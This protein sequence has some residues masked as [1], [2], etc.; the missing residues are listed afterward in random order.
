MVDLML[1]L[2]RLAAGLTATP[3]V[4]VVE[5]VMAYTAQRGHPSVKLQVED[6]A[7][8]SMRFRGGAFGQIIGATSMYPGTHRRLLIGGRD[9]TAEMIEDQ[10]S[11]FQFRE[12]LQTD[13]IC[14]AR[15]GL[16]CGNLAGASDPTNVHHQGHQACIEQFL[17]ALESGEAP[18]VSLNEAAES[19]ALIQACYASAKLGRPVVP[20]RLANDVPACETAS[21]LR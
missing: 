9:G 1:W 3:V 5:E 10:L 12:E 2:A 18:M 19:V 15:F 4:G 6:T 14:R 7:V 8:A 21:S 13:A 16:Q 20:E 17:H 11:V